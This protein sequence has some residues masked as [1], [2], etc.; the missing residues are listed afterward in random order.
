MDAGTTVRGDDFYNFHAVPQHAAAIGGGLAMLE[1]AVA[2]FRAALAAEQTKGRSRSPVVVG[3]YGCAGGR[4][5]VEPIAAMIAGIR[6]VDPTRPIVVAHIDRPANDFSALLQGEPDGADRMVF[7]II[8]GRSFY[9]PVLPPATLSLGWS[10]HSVH[11]LSRAPTIVPDHVFIP[12]AGAEVREPW[13]ARAAADWHAFLAHRAV[14]LKPGGQLVIELAAIAADGTGGS[15]PLYAL[16]DQALATLVEDGRLT[17]AEADRIAMPVYNRTERE[18]IA[19]FHATDLG[20]LLRL[21]D[22]RIRSSPDPFLK[23]FQQTGD[24]LAFAGSWTATVRAF[25]EQALFGA[26]VLPDRS[27]TA[28]AELADG[29]YHL[30]FELI[31]ADPL[32]ASNHWNVADLRIARTELAR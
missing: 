27:G 25:S 30:L 22:L 6:A 10:G 23:A 21:E 29:F 3:D 5:S 11:W 31:A 4:N 16:L 19:P 26:S 17:K 32:R 2:V 8:V 9:G 12:M 20:E 7:P 1:E 14:E 28:R 18:L 24:A 13:A 15:E